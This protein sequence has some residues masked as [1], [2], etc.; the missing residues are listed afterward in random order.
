M[1]T[2]NGPVFREAMSPLVQQPV[3]LSV[4]T[5]YLLSPE[6]CE[7]ERPSAFPFFHFTL[8]PDIS[9]NPYASLLQVPEF[10]FLLSSLSP[11]SDPPFFFVPESFSA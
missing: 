1:R 8:T 3:D 4:R 10:F 9:P 2:H 5:T 6:E 11:N 7:S